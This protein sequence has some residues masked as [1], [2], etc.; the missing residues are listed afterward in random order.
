MRSFNEVIKTVRE[1]TAYNEELKTINHLYRALRHAAKGN[2]TGQEKAQFHELAEFVS[3][4]II[5][6]L[7][8]GE[9]L[10]CVSAVI[11]VA[12]ALL[13]G[14]IIGLATL[15]PTLND[16]SDSALSLGLLVL[17]L[18]VIIPTAYLIV[19]PDGIV[20]R[21][22]EKRA[23]HR[24]QWLHALRQNTYEAYS[25]ANAPTVRVVHSDN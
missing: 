25:L 21:I 19:K 10:L 12:E 4:R 6:D 9:Q 15:F 5:Y 11:I 18:L 3:D 24:E 16:V 23:K 22:A 17:S 8:F 13:I 2:P 14:I 1:N 20:Y 7:T